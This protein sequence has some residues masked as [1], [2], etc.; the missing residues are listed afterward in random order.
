MVGVSNVYSEKTPIVHNRITVE[1]TTITTPFV[2]KLLSLQYQD[3]SNQTDR[4]QVHW[5]KSTSQAGKP[6]VSWAHS[7][8]FTLCVKTAAEALS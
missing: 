4:P 2:S 8:R 1:K 3:G 7:R 6:N 5:R